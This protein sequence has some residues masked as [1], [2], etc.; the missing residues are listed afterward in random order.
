M[1]KEYKVDNKLKLKLIISSYKKHPFWIKRTNVRRIVFA[2]SMLI[3][4]GITVFMY[5]GKKDIE[6]LLIGGAAGVII[7]G[8]P[9][10]AYWVALRDTCSE[11][12][13][14]KT[15]ETLTL[16]NEELVNLYLPYR[17]KRYYN[18]EEDIFKYTKIQKLEYYED[19]KKLYIY[20]NYKNRYYINYFNNEQ[21]R[22]NGVRGKNNKLVLFMYYENSDDFLKTLSEKCKKDIIYYGKSGGYNE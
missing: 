15:N 4:I 17:A 21:G 2:I 16:G 22:E 11:G 13:R 12:I 5:T 14:S 10:L 1:V 7:G 8:I 3:I 6:G 18:Y 20:G 19:A 9:Y